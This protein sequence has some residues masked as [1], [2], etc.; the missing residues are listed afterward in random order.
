MSAKIIAAVFMGTAI[1]NIVIGAVVS[2][3]SSKALQEMMYEDMQH[4]VNAVAKEMDLHNEREMRMLETLA[5]VPQIK[6]PSPCSR[7]TR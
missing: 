4:S 2:R 6:E 3:G 5:N 7:N 1:S